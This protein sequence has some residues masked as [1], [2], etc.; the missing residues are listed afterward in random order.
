MEL[1]NFINEKQINNFNTLKE[2]LEAGPYN[3]KIKEDVNHPN[4]F[5]IHAKNDS[6][7]SLK[8]VNE[9]NGII[10]DKNNF[11]IV[12]YT[13]DKCS[14]S[15][16]LD[17]KLDKNNLYYEYSLEGTLIRAFYYENKWIFSTKKCVDASK[18][19]WLSKKNFKELFLEC[20]GE[21]YIFDNLNKNNCYSFIIMHPDNNIVLQNKDPTIIHVSTRDM[22]NLKEIDENINIYKLSKVVVNESDLT[23]ILSNILNDTTLD[24][25]GFIFIDINYNRWKLKKPFFCKVRSLWG[26][27]NNRFY[28]YLELR[29]DNNLLNEYLNYFP[30][31]KDKLIEYEIKINNFANILLSFYIE[32]H[33]KKTNN[34]LPFYFVKIIYQLHG[35][36][37]KDRI[38]TNHDKVMLK[39]LSLEANKLCFIINSYEKLLIKDDISMDI[40]DNV[41]G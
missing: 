9:C 26:N 25:E 35:D 14:D 34:N 5:L 7:F 18:S 16:E 22:I 36:Y 24:F 8:I 13:F 30:Q 11:K 27:S 41:H 33:I 28:R 10:L 32:K 2:I 20:I 1:L 37:L 39:L 15:L 6:D 21:N 40:V 3:L 38:V 31:D 12:C 19:Y 17:N 4:L 23:L 29:K